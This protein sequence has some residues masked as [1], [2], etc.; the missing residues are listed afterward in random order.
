MQNLDKFYNILCNFAF[1]K[2]LRVI[3]TNCNCFCLKH[4]LCSVFFVKQFDKI[5]DIIKLLC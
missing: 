5:I 3:N 2:R 4:F 1:F